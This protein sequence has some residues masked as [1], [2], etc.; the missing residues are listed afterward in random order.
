[1]KYPLVIVES[2]YGKANCTP[3]ELA[4]R[5]AYARAA[6]HDCLMR[7]EAPFASHLLYTQPGV[8]EDT[9]PVERS[10]GIEAGL[11]W[12]E[13]AARTVV[14]TDLGISTGMK[15]G[16]AHAE[17]HSRPVEYRTLGWDQPAPDGPYACA[18]CGASIPQGC[19][20]ECPGKAGP[21]RVQGVWD[22]DKKPC[23]CLNGC[24]SWDCDK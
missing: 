5:E 18:D 3:E 20:H 11:A 10:H 7:G 24:K 2:P 14:Y 22:H 15:H 4:R 21:R 16:I 12:A 8:L 17:R 1:M 23:P 9:D 13:V 6:L 19:W